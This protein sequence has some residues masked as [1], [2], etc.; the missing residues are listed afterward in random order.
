MCAALEVHA[1][2]VIPRIEDRHRSREFIAFMDQLTG[3]YPLGD[4]T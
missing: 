2:R 4:S 1:G 3:A